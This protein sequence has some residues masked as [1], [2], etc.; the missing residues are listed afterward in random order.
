MQVFAHEIKMQKKEKQ[1]IPMASTWLN[2]K[3]YL[4]FDKIKPLNRKSL[5]AIAG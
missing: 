2:Q 3:R 4:E 5:N 1:F